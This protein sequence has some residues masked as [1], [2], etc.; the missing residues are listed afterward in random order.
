MK[1]VMVVIDESYSSYELL[2]WVLQNLKDSIRSSKVLIF[3]TQ[4]LVSINPS[5][6]ASFGYAQ[7][8]F[9]FSA[10]A[11]LTWLAQKKSKTICLGILE[12]AKKICADHGIKAETVTEAGD[13]KDVI[14]RIA[15]EHK[16]DSL[17]ITDQHNRNLARFSS[18][19]LSG[20]CSRKAK[21]SVL[22]VKSET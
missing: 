19:G 12:R 6:F 8:F 15:E 9:P 20:Y 14:C 10:N 11:E 4:P 1:N 21:C 16:I 22:V 13:P 7:M 3:A 5:L 18:G 2:F 17:V